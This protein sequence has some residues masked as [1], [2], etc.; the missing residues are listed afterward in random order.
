MMLRK[1]PILLAPL[2]LV[3]ILPYLA[4]RQMAGVRPLWE[5]HLSLVIV[6]AC[7]LAAAAVLRVG[8]KSWS[9]AAYGVS[10]LAVS[11]ISTTAM[12][13]VLAAG[14]V[15]T[16]I[17]RR[18]DGEKIMLV[19]LV[20]ALAQLRLL[21]PTLELA[22]YAPRMPALEH[23][24]PEVGRF[25]TRPSVVHI[26]MDAYGAPAELARDYGHD[27]TPFLNALK[28]RGFTIFAPTLTPFNQTAMVMASSLVS[29]G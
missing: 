12:L 17:E 13:I 26:L 9:A 8:L 3:G 19:V 29:T 16:A 18:F 6:L 2:I 23:P 24:A 25:R 20:F 22:F 27:A 21:G 15:L 11:Q 14:A 7:A 28:K 4:W 5:A 1:L 10:L